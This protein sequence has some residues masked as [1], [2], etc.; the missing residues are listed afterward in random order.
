VAG[1]FGVVTLVKFIALGA[2]GGLLFVVSAERLTSLPE[3]S[4]RAQGLLVHSANTV[5]TRR[6]VE[7][8]PPALSDP[9]KTQEI[10]GAA[11][12]SRPPVVSGESSSGHRIPPSSSGRAQSSSAR[13]NPLLAPEI[14]FVDR[15]R[16]AFQR[17]EFAA[18][19]ALLEGYE[20]T[21]SDARL[22]PEVLYLRMQ[23]LHQSGQAKQAVDLARHLVREFPNSAHAASARAVLDS[24]R[25]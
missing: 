24:A 22:L 17:G 25:R 14:A 13:Q 23:A 1:S 7:A 15:G 19:L 16:S 2:A 20:R 3:A 8:A 18:T 4:R 9:R 12:E 11:S 6:A 5:R 21:F 10:Q